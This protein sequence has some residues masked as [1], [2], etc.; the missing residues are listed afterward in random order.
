MVREPIGP[1]VGRTMSKAEARAKASL[2]GEGKVQRFLDAGGQA[3]QRVYVGYHF[4][5]APQPELVGVLRHIEIG[6]SEYIRDGKPHMLFISIQED[7]KTDRTKV[8]IRNLN[9]IELNTDPIPAA[10]TE[11]RKAFEVVYVK[12]RRATSRKD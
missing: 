1:R 12:R 9:S 7:G 10:T 4:N 11:P 6:Q 3:G 5:G 2:I 8:R